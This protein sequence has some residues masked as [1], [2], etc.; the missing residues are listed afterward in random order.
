M[1]GQSNAGIGKDE[2]VVARPAIFG[3]CGFLDPKLRRGSHRLRGAPSPKGEWKGERERDREK[4]WFKS[5]DIWVRVEVSR[6]QICPV[7]SRQKSDLMCQDL[8][9]LSTSLVI[10]VSRSAFD[11]VGG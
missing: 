4:W 1:E 9:P 11:V 8:I 7:F 3:P 5:G 6:A 2:H 10:I